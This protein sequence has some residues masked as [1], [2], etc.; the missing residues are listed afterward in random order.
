MRH[1]VPSVVAEA[2]IGVA[3]S[4]AIFFC[5]LDGGVEKGMLN[6]CLV[7]EIRTRLFGVIIV[8][9]V[10]VID[11]LDLFVMGEAKA[12]FWFSKLNNGHFHRNFLRKSLAAIDPRVFASSARILREDKKCK[13]KTVPYDAKV[14]GRL[15]GE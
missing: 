1:V 10:K 7:L 13:T 12:G 2:S 3:A 15:S 6:Y 5:R 4:D 8:A 14:L 11:N 9:N